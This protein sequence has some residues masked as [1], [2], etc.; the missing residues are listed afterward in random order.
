MQLWLAFNLLIRGAFNLDAVSF[1]SWWSLSPVVIVYHCSLSPFATIIYHHP[2]SPS[3]IY[4]DC[5]LLLP[6]PMTVI[7]PIA[8]PVIVDA[9]SGHCHCPLSPLTSIFIVHSC[10]LCH[11]RCPLPPS[12]TTVSCCPLF[13]SP[14]VVVSCHHLPL[15]NNIFVK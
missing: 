5:P 8:L 11:Y 1:S 2:I 10:I 13:L 14:T 3:T 9:I 15:P 12:A 6:L 7:V 4:Q